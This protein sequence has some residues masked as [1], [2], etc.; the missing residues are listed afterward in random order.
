MGEPTVSVNPGRPKIEAAAV[1]P[2]WVHIPL[3]RSV[4]G[5]LSSVTP[6]HEAQIAA[7][8]PAPS[9]P[10][11]GQSKN[12][13]GQLQSPRETIRSKPELGGRQGPDPTRYGDWE[14]RGRCIDF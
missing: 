14:L 5:T 7:P 3:F 8:P 1:S 10:S 6:T 4:S 12:P 11:E 13:S 9:Q 2:H